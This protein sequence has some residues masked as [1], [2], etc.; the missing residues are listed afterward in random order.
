MQNYI[1]ILKISSNLELF[2]K[3]YGKIKINN[4]IKKRIEYEKNLISKIE[5]TSNNIYDLFKKKFKESRQR[6]KSLEDSIFNACWYIE[7]IYPNI[8]NNIDKRL[9][10][11]NDRNKKNILKHIKNYCEGGKSQMLGKILP[12]VKILNS[13]PE[14]PTHDINITN[15]NQGEKKIAVKIPT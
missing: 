6:N 10:N 14:V 12:D 2:Y 3:K 4:I 15:K 5:K 13:L 8:C 1:E 9:L 7:E 11:E